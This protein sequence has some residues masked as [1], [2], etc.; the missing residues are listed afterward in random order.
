MIYTSQTNQS[1]A[2][3]PWKVQAGSDQTTEC[4]HS[5]VTL[6]YLHSDKM[7][8]W[9]CSNRRNVSEIWN[10]NLVCTSQKTGDR[11]DLFSEYILNILLLKGQFLY[12]SKV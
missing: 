5:S 12:L 6:F 1:A 3:L 10:N 11:Q 4:N 7:Y 8:K 2:A 9:S